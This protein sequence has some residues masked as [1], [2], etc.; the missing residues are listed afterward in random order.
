MIDFRDHDVREIATHDVLDSVFDG[1][2]LSRA[3]E[4]VPFVDEASMQIQQEANSLVVHARVA[5]KRPQPYRVIFG[6]YAMDTDL[7]GDNIAI[8]A[9]CSCPVGM[10]C[11]HAAALG[12]L[13]AGAEGQDDA[14]RRRLEALSA[15]LAA[16]AHKDHY[17]NFALHFTLFA[18]RLHSDVVLPGM[19]PLRPGKKQNWV[20]SGANWNKIPTLVSQRILPPAQAGVLHALYDALISNRV[21]LFD[22]AVPS[23][24]GFGARLP[25]LLRE[26]QDAG[27]VF[28]T[29]DSLT[30][31]SVRHEPVTLAASTSVEDD[32]ASLQLGVTDG[33]ELWRDEHLHL[34]GKPEP[35]VAA[36]Y[37]DGR[38]QLAELPAAVPATVAKLMDEPPLEIPVDEL[39]SYRDILS[40][41]VQHV[42]IWS[43]DNSIDIPEPITPTLQATVTWASVASAAV[44]W[45]W[46]YG[47][48]LQCAWDSADALGGVR[49]LS[50]EESILASIPEHMLKTTNYHD[51]DALSLAI[52]DL[53][54]LHGLDNVEVD[55]QYRPD[56]REATEAPTVGFELADDS[57]PDGVTDWLDLQVT[58]TV[59]GETVPLA[60]VLSSLTL[61]SEYI[62]LPSGLYVSTDHPEFDSLREI[63]DAASQL[64]DH[65]DDHISVGKH[66]LGLWAQLADLGI[67]SEQADVWVQRARA[68]R[69]LTEIP[70][71][72]PDGLESTLRSYQ[73]AGFWWLAFLYQHRL[74]GI[75]ADDMGL[76]KTLQVLALVQHA[77]AQGASEP[78]LVV[79][80]ASVITAWQ[81]EAQKHTPGL[82]LGVVSRRS[83]DI[84]AI[85]GESDIV[86]TSYTL[87]RLE[88]DAF[89]A[90]TWQGLILDE[91][92]QVK[93]HQGKTYAAARRIPTDF[94]LAMTGT[95]FENRLM[96]LW[97]LLSLTVPGIYPWPNEFKA[98]VARPVENEGDSRVLDSFRRRIHPFMLRRTKELV[99]P[100]L[101]AKQEQVVDVTL[102]TKQRKIYDAHLAKERQKILGLVEDFDRNRI[103]IFSALTKLR[104]LALDP[105]LIGEDD[106]AGSAKL[107]LLVDQLHEITREGHKVLVF[108]QFTSYLQRVNDRLAA[109]GI[110]TSYLDGGTRNRGTVINEFRTGTA[111][112]FLIS[113]KAGGSGLTLTEAD[114]VFMLDPWWN[115]AVEAQAVD[116][117]HRIGQDKPVHVYRLVSNGTIEQKVMDLKERKA[118]LFSQVIDGDASLATGIDADDI[119]NLFDD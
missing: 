16:P 46:L 87:L 4:Y 13:L 49:N 28:I 47:N 6:V 96:D 1:V 62:L 56:F 72:E 31:V 41:L 73:R 81:A 15:A 90:R 110:A 19:R 109:E 40:G 61:A 23:L 29:D 51:G 86:V 113:L 22:G 91:A 94:H 93:N 98:T 105:A 42:T 27:I 39:D 84:D 55:E 101:P 111:P 79:A 66:D 3:V 85:A 59:C 9:L 107:D 115:P 14:W 25:L 80:P 7:S 99:A 108:S 30:S 74:G 20:K 33:V 10:M 45:T 26:A 69:D 48:A 52:H 5:G 92:Q 77:R 37:D 54:F 63:V 71:P 8:R 97:A 32:R 88:H 65:D 104:Q 11:K 67:V 95:P 50:A 76:G 112:V 17:E 64:H 34:L 119:R 103:A 106:S 83:D 12:L 102:K 60:A 21:Y 118:G 18:H 89:T 100:D 38:L 24:D 43:P 117:A 35:S 68:L 70:R 36:L 44:E 2:T 114:Y 116:R 82:R 53:P 58:V 78:F 75:L 57:P